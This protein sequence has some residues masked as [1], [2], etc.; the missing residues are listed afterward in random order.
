M[1]HWKV[2]TVQGARA[3]AVVGAPHAEHG[4]ADVGEPAAAHRHCEENEGER[5]RKGWF[6]DGRGT[7]G[8]ARLV[9]RYRVV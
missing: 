9:L 1:I 2:D 6:P 5:G 3:A 8:G 7:G 4:G